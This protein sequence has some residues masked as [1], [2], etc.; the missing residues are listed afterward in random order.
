MNHLVQMAYEYYNWKGY[1]VKNN[2]HVGKRKQ[3]GYE[4]ELDIVAYNPNSKHLIHIETS[5]DADSWERRRERYSKIFSIGEKY[6]FFEVF[7]WLKKDEKI[8]QLIVGIN[9][10]NNGLLN[11]IKIIYVGEFTGIII[12]EFIKEGKANKKAIPEQFLI[13]RTIQ[14]CFCGYNNK[15]IMV[16]K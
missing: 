7:T 14:Y 12:N 3:G 11:G 5:L 9:K 8:D 2:I 1:L 6:I 10:I 15:P 16:E 13:L 4:M